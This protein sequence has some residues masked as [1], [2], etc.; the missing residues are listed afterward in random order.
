MLSRKRQTGVS[1]LGFLIGCAL[2]GFFAYLGMRLWPIVNEKL[3]VDMA[4]KSVAARPDI[5]NLG[6]ADIGKYML[7]H[8][9]VEDVDQFSSMKDMKDIFMVQRIKGEKK[10]L[11]T[12]AYEIRRP[13]IANLDVVLKYNKSIEIDGLG[14]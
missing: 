6:K 11:M 2:V 7:R 13:M 14:E 8:F 1:F 12:M 9:E 3:K 10:R 4:M 5:A